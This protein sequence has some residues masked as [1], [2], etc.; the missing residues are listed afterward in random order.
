MSLAKVNVTTAL[1][2]LSLTHP[3]LRVAHKIKVEPVLDWEGGLP[4][5]GGVWKN[6]TPLLTPTLPRGLLMMTPLNETVNVMRD[7][8]AQ[9]PR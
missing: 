3:G 9:S 8:A 5:N 2:F 7:L 4:V 1:G 6:M